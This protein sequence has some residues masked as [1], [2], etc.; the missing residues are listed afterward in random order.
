MKSEQ[1]KEMVVVKMMK[2]MK[3]VARWEKLPPKI[4]LS[5]AGLVVY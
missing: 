3:L 5:G 4:D 2:A 1:Q